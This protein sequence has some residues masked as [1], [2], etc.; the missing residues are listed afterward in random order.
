MQ[1]LK[2]VKE[3][4]LKTTAFY[5]QQPH[6]PDI[7]SP[8][9][10]TASVTASTIPKPGQYLLPPVIVWDPLLQFPNVFNGQILCNKECHSN[11]CAPL[12][13]KRWKNGQSEK[14]APRHLYGKEC[15]VL[16]VSRV[17][18][19]GDGHEILAHDPWIVDKIPLESV[20]FYLSHKSGVTRKLVSLIISLASSGLTFAEVERHVA[21]QYYDC[22]WEREV[23][24]RKNTRHF[25]EK[26][27]ESS[28][29]GNSEPFP[30]FEAWVKLPSDDILIGCF[31]LHFEEI[32]YFTQRECRICQ[33]ST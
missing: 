21:Q 29:K 13:P 9:L 10:P 5:E 17:Y 3:Y 24:F 8:P 28:E 27:G 12:I 6:G 31:I 20:P 26:C 23:S 2:E 18:I 19:C 11:C 32:T 33:P 7:I 22:H 4:L 16:L 25:K 15:F 14:D 1:L 30:G